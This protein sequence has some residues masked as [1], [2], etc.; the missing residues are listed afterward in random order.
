[1]RYRRPRHRETFRFVASPSSGSRLPTGSRTSRLARQYGP[2]YTPRP[3]QPSHSTSSL[4]IISMPPRYALVPLIALAASCAHQP[5]TPVPIPTTAA[6]PPTAST[7][8]TPPTTQFADAELNEYRDSIQQKL[9]AGWEMTTNGMTLLL[10]KLQP[11]R[12]VE[13]YSSM[14]WMHGR[15]PQAPQ[16]GMTELKFWVQITPLVTHAEYT[17]ILNANEERQRRNRNWPLAIR[18]TQPA[19]FSDQIRLSLALARLP[20]EAPLRLP[21]YYGSSFSI[22]MNLALPYGAIADGSARQEYDCVERAITECL[23]PYARTAIKRR[24]LYP[25]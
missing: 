23:K 21:D 2:T 3:V 14:V 13:N 18:S 20:A 19:R 22:S 12:F 5:P 1:M 15:R 11:I 6:A 25:R 9:P 17:H 16:Y 24:L 10:R 7:P 8:A 4:G